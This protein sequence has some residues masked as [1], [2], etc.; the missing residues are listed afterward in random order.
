[1]ANVV[2][3]YK[4]EIDVLIDKGAELPPLYT[5][6]SKCAYRFVFREEN[7]N[8]HKPVYIQKPQ[9]AISKMDK[10]EFDT[11]GYALS[12]FEQEDNA[13][14]KFNKLKTSYPNIKLAVG[15]ALCSGILDDRDG[16][17]TQSNKETHFD[18]YE[19]QE[20]DLSKTFEVIRILV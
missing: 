1:M 8:N 11:S 14:Q 19:Y 12:C 9:R 16:L 15:D 6:Q 20:C 10:N 4:S 2:F 7:P 5:P 3:K 18:L 13:I 17:I